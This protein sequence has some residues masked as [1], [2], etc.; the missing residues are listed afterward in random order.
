MK[1][2]KVMLQIQIEE[3]DAELLHKMISRM[4]CSNHNYARKVVFSR[5]LR[6]L[7]GKIAE[8]KVARLTQENYNQVT[9]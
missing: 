2:E 9:I 5:V 8:V 3:Y 4:M 6:E 1:K 7:E